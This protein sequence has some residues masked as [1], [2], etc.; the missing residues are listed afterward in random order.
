MPRLETERIKGFMYSLRLTGWLVGAVLV[1]LGAAGLCMGT[2][3]RR[4]LE[5][6][7]RSRPAAIL[8]TLVNVVWVALFLYHTPLGRF[9][10]V[11]PWIPVLAPLALVL[12]V[13]FM[14]ELLAPRMLG[15]LL[16]LAA[17]PVLEAA[18]WHDSPWRLVLTGLAYVWIVWAM[19]VM[20]SPY[21]F[22]HTVEWVYTGRRTGAVY[23]LWLA[24]GGTV[25]F[26]AMWIY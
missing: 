22:R 1:L 20:L 8:L 11:Q 26:L 5:R 16:L 4:A 3:T 21:R 15:G 13:V 10:W 24:L 19:V 23:G 9:A 25:W 18:R 17:H 7:P 2:S 6:F 14:D 12:V